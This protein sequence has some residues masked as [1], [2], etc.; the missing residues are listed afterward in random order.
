MDETVLDTQ[1]CFQGDGF[2]GCD[3]HPGDAAQTQGN[4]RENAISFAARV[5]MLPWDN[6]DNGARGCHTASF[7]WT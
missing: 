4:G 1:R 7:A 3:S 5:L 6:S 2:T